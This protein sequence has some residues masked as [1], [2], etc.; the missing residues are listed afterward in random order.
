MIP[1][2][3]NSKYASQE[4]PKVD[5]IPYTPSY[6]LPGSEWLFVKC[7]LPSDNENYFLLEHCKPFIDYLR[8]Q[9]IIEEWFFVRYADPKNHL[10]LRFR[11][12]NEQILTRLM[13]NLEQWLA[14]LLNNGLISQMTF[15]P[16]E[17]EI[18]R[19]GNDPELIKLAEFLFCADSD[20]TLSLLSFANDNNFLPEEIVSAISVLDILKGFFGVDIE[21]Q[22]A[23]LTAKNT[24]KDELKGL[25]KNKSQL[26]SLGEAVLHNTLTISEEGKKLQV[27]F[28]KRSESLQ[29]YVKALEQQQNQRPYIIDSIIHMHCNR[30]L[31]KDPKKTKMS[32]LRTTHSF[33]SKK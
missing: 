25:R 26:L 12:T 27:V 17:Q 16:Y 14:S 4:H 9:Q 28:H 29:T 23:F 15:S 24:P 21:R 2:I 11:G 32:P 31:G 5:C 10:R 1:I 18:A 3:K 8:K 6:K 30:Y 7:Y 19:Y 13:P 33:M 22:Y 20:T